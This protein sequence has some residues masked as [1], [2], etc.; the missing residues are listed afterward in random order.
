MKLV[1]YSE[2]LSLCFYPLLI[3]NGSLPEIKISLALE[4]RIVNFWPQLTYSI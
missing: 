4:I 2:L 1:A 3:V